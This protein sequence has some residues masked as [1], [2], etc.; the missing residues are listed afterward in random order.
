MVIYLEF[1]DQVVA[2]SGKNYCIRF[3]K[4]ALKCQQEFLVE[5]NNF[6]VAGYIHIRI[7][8]FWFNQISQNS[9]AYQPTKRVNLINHFYSFKYKCRSR[10]VAIKNSTLITRHRHS[11]RK[12]LHV[13]KRYKTHQTILSAFI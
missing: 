11:T 4:T 3:L 1:L 2:M 10:S 12:F 13:S 8:G 5:I 6:T 9:A 7:L